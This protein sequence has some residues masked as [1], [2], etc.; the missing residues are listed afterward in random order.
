MTT[1]ASAT[2]TSSQMVFCGEHHQAVG[3]EIEIA[4]RNWILRL[5][6]LLRKF[7]DALSANAGSVFQFRRDSCKQRLR[8]RNARTPAWP[9]MTGNTAKLTVI[10][11]TAQRAKLGFHFFAFRRRTI[12]SDRTPMAAIIDA[13][14]SGTTETASICVLPLSTSIRRKLALCR[15]TGLPF[16]S[17][18]HDKSK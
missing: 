8:Y 1:T 7:A 13:P 6:P 15:S 9:F 2:V 12:A 18:A 4:R 5:S 11:A 14:G 17:R 3:I 10:L 16:S